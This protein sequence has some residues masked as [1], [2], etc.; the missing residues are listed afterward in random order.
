MV[1]LSCT[2]CSFFL[3]YRCFCKATRS[4]IKINCSILVW[5][6][7]VKFVFYQGVQV[8]I[9]LSVPVRWNN[10]LTVLMYFILNMRNISQCHTVPRR[11]TFAISALV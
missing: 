7:C 6:R 4:S 5:N 3:N 2:N 9:H 8:L 1:V 10:Y 11:A